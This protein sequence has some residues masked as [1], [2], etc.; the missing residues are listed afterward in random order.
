MRTNIIR[1]GN[2]Q[3]IRIPKVLLEQSHLGAEVELEVEDEKIIIRSASRPRQ[4]WGEKFQLMAESGDDRMLNGDA[5]EQTEWD[6]D[7]WEW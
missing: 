4:G 5:G 7:E 2:S 3:G 6:K 1:I